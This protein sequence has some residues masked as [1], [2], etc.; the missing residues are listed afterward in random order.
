M[1]RLKNFME[2]PN[3]GKQKRHNFDC[4]SGNY[5]RFASFGTEL[6]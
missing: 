5:N 2:D 6:A 3:D 4:V 1:F